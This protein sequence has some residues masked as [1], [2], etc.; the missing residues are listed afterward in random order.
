[1]CDKEAIAKALLTTREILDKHSVFFWLES[2]TLLGAMREKD[3]IEGD[4]DADLSYH[5]KDSLRILE[6]RKDFKD[7]GYD[8]RTP[9]SKF[10]IWDIKTNTHLVC[11]MPVDTKKGWA[12][13]VQFLLPLHYLDALLDK[14]HIKVFDKIVWKLTMKLNLYTDWFV[15]CPAGMLARFKTATI[16]NNRYFVPE[17]AESYLTYKYG[18]WKIPKPGEKGFE[19]KKL[20]DVIY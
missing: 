1:M 3:I 14:L 15:R 7:S 10:E 16:Q 4:D 18:H 19:K 17:Y 20:K 2:G 13:R 8:L 6:T 9:G 5:F 11:L 12:Y